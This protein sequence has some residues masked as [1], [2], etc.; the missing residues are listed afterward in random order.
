M[1]YITIVTARAYDRD[2][3]YS[4]VDDE[5]ITKHFRD[6]RIK[7]FCDT[8]IVKSV[9]VYEAT[10]ITEDTMPAK[11]SPDVHINAQ[12]EEMLSKMKPKYAYVDT[13]QHLDKNKN[14]KTQ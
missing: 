14:E 3:V 6:Q 1:K 13:P 2:T 4:F 12:A 5:I 11:P 10:L 8:A 9:Q 7:E